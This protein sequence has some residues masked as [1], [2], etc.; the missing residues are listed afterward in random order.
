MLNFNY[1]S[2]YFWD[3]VSLT[4]FISGCRMVWDLICGISCFYKSKTEKV[5]GGGK[6]AILPN[7]CCL[8]SITVLFTH[9]WKVS[10]T[11]LMSLVC[12]IWILIRN[13]IKNFF[14][15]KGNRTLS[16]MNVLKYARSWVNCYA[17]QNQKKLS[18]QVT[19]LGMKKLANAVVNHHVMN[20]K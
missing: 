20:P 7:W 5:T 8:L 4:K 2:P 13:L 9:P 11:T 10:L 1:G 12:M 16:N 6:S 17:G 19:V 3:K 14:S 18:R 15:I